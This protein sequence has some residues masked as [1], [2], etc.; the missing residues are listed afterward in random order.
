MIS[1]IIYAD[2][3]IVLNAYVDYILILS[4]EKIFKY[5]IKLMRRVCG[6]FLGAATSLSIFIPIHSKLLSFSIGLV[7]SLLICVVCFGFKK[8]GL[9]IKSCTVLYILSC[10]YC[11]IMMLIWSVAQ[12]D[13]IVINNNVVYFNVSPMFL[14]VC[15]V[16]CYFV[17]SAVSKLLNKRRAMPTCKVDISVKDRSISLK[18]MIDTGNTLHDQLS[19]LPVIVINK[20]SGLNL[21]K[22]DLNTVDADGLIELGLDSFRII[23]CSSAAGNGCLPAFKPDSIMMSVDGEYS[24]VN[25]YIAVSNTDFS[26]GF[27]AIVGAQFVTDK[28][29]LLCC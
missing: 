8:L 9:L 19:G 25:A 27:D 10:T 7:S 13:G 11:G 4:T 12:N 21:L 23:P 15:T 2:V 28:E 6:A 22:T 18:G 3:L 20:R 1:L 5:E 16:V 17:I 26:E 14:I 29:S 24:F